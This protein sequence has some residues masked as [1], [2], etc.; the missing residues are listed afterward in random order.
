M[1]R[2]RNAVS[3]RYISLKLPTNR[4]TV[5]IAEILPEELG[6]KPHIRLSSLG[7]PHQEDKSLNVWLWRPVKFAYRWKA[8]GNRLLLK[9]ACKISHTPRPHTEAVIWKDPGSDLLA[10]LILSERQE[11]TGACPGDVDTGG[12][13]LGSSLYREDIGADKYDFGILPVA[14]SYL[15]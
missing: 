15:G 12:S 8:V 11:A 1:D 14:Y 7:V 6:S 4:R 5:T 10:G 9:G 13:H 3:S 2:S